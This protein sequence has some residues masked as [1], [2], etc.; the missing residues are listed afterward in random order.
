MHGSIALVERLIK[1]VKTE[2]LG[3]SALWMT[4]TMIRE[5]VARYLVWYAHNRLHQGLSG[6]TPHD[7]ARRAAPKRLKNIE[8]RDQ[9]TLAC[10]NRFGDPRLPVYRLLQLRR[11]A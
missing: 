8:K 2:A 1:T 10:E 3:F 5:C 9:F 6:R 11:A 7:A 4:E